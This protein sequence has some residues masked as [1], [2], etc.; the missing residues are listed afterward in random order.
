MGTILKGAKKNQINL[1]MT[2][3][4]TGGYYVFASHPTT[5]PF[6]VDNNN[7]PA[8]TEAIQDSLHDT[9]NN[10]LF[11]KKVDVANVRIM[12]P[13][14]NW[15]AN[16]VYAQYSHIDPSLY[17][18]NFFVITDENKV[19][20]CLYNNKGTPSIN[21]P[22]LTQNSAF[23]TAGDGYVWKYMYS[24]TSQ[25]MSNF[26]TTYYIPVVANTTVQNSANSGLDVIE[27]F[28]GGSGYI[29]AVTGT[30]QSILNSSTL[31]IDSYASQDNDFYFNSAFYV[32]SGPGAGALRTITKHV[33][34]S[35]GNWVFLDTPTIGLTAG[36]SKYSI[37][38]RVK[39]SGDGVGAQ[40]VLTVGNNQAI[41]SVTIINQGDGYSRAN[42][43]VV[44]NT[45]YGTGANLVAYV[46]PPGGHGFKPI[47]E[48]GADA[49]CITTTFVNT[50]AGKAITESNYR[51]VGLLKGPKYA[52]GFS[53]TANVFNQVLKCTTV[54]ATVF[55]VGEVLV[56]STSGAQGSVI[57]SN[58]SL[59][60]M[61][62]DKDFVTTE[63][64]TSQN[65]ATFT[66]I[67]TITDAGDLGFDS[68]SPDI[69]YINNNT[70]TPRSNTTSETIKLI[71]KV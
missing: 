61:V 21:K 45:S 28:G 54:P 40:A 38:P 20:K 8:S 35:T 9:Q 13:R 27:I 55:G 24:V 58:T 17:D 30:V 19:F 65:T 43:Q 4:G 1:T 31:Q 7:P 29:T 18:K 66:S 39:I 5:T 64:I 2:D 36:A 41:N 70:L 26:A 57:F 52:N 11:G 56:G 59:L 6:W 10:L 14:Y 16:N 12:A 15:T 71:F 47:M 49:F 46:A 33:A 25:D 63:T 3:I 44:A 22:T 48:L 53:F 42:V 67:S 62:G 51:R 50:E 37:A 68:N 60:M 34:N 23:T 69:L 32:Y